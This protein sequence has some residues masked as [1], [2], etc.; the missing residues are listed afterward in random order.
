MRHNANNTHF[1]SIMETTVTKT[2]K[3]NYTDTNL[4][5]CVT[6]KIGQ[7]KKSKSAMLYH[8]THPKSINI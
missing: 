4:N 2:H 7:P 8:I 6:N 5:L 1:I 3:L